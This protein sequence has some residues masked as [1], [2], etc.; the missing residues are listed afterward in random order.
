VSP[1]STSRTR[2]PQALRA[3]VG[4]KRGADGAHRGEAQRRRH[5]TSS[6]SK[7]IPARRAATLRCAC[8]AATLAHLR[9]RFDL[10]THGKNTCGA[11]RVCSPKSRIA[12]SVAALLFWCGA[13]CAPVAS[14]GSL[15]GGGDRER[16]RRT[17]QWRTARIE[18][19]IEIQRREREWGYGRLHPRGAGRRT[20]ASR[21]R[22]ACPAFLLLR[23]ASSVSWSTSRSPV[24]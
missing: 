22:D 6:A 21:L 8:Q 17:R 14:K 23:G 19:F 15:Y 12:P 16:D 10:T 20:V 1:P 5:Q 2:P 9:A 7:P 13:R 4:Q 18:R 11:A 3:P 24:S